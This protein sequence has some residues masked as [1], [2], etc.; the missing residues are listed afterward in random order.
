MVIA[1]RYRAVAGVDE[2]RPRGRVGKPMVSLLGDTVAEAVMMV[3]Q[4]TRSRAVAIRL[5]RHRSR[6]RASAIHVI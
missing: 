2:R 5:E 1:A 4:P 6:W 3:H